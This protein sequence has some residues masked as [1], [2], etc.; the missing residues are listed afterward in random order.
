MG[1]AA[2]AMLGD[3]G[4][5]GCLGG[6]G[7]S[8]PILLFIGSIGAGALPIYGVLIPSESVAPARV[9]SHWSLRPEK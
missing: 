2:G 4:I 3:F 7:L 9:L 6:V 1:L 5:A 8:L